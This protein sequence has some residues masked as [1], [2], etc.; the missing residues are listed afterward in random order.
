MALDLSYIGRTYPASAPYGVSRAKIREFAESIGDDNPLYTDPA[1]ATAAGFPDVVVPPTFLT[2]INLAAINVVIED[3][4]LGL[5]YGRMV[6]GDQK[7]TYRRQ[8]HAGDELRVVVHIEDIM[9]RA[10]NDFINLRADVYDADDEI[11][12]V[13]HAQLVVREAEKPA[14]VTG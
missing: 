6:H 7:F 8:V 10:G 2:I 3:P 11:V 14:E 5:D 13:C 9:F 4:E 1:A 12:V